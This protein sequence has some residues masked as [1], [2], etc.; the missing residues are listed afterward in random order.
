MSSEK[1]SALNFAQATCVSPGAKVSSIPQ[2]IR[3]PSALGWERDTKEQP[4]K[5]HKGGHGTIN[6]ALEATAKE[7]KGT[8]E[9][10]AVGDRFELVHGDGS[11][12]L[13]PDSP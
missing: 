7:F 4:N 6:E 3:P 1:A 9:S 2:L 5:T 12:K 10:Q 13:F 8:D 11:I